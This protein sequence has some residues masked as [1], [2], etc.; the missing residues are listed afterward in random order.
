[1]NP[2]KTEE[3]PCPL[4]GSDLKIRAYLGFH[5]YGVVR[6]KSCDFYYLSPRLTEEAM[7]DLYSKNNYFEGEGSG[8]QN[9]L[10]QEK[11]LRATFRRLLINLSD[12]KL[13]GGSLLEIGCG[14]GYLLDE[15]KNF[16]QYRVG[17]DFSAAALEYAKNRADRVCQGGV[18]AIPNEELFDC[19]ISSQVIEHVYDPKKFLQQTLE[20]LKPRG[21]V[22]IA[23]PDMGSF[24][25]HIMGHKWSSF[26]MPEH[27]LFFDK[28][29][30]SSL[31]KESGI[32]NIKTISYPH[33]FPLTLV[34]SKFN[35]RLPS[36]LNKYNLWIPA[37]TLA[38]SGNKKC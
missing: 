34:A 12:R 31:M 7:L 22:V 36:A 10:Q 26:K 21:K 19:I 14:Y 38:L 25:R 18:D 32:V 17:T 29:T 11:A 24:W 5:P 27:V 35:I 6:C 30:L 1:M 33:A 15:S 9:Y 3:I 13:T 8:Y 16:F 23:T 37:T 4:C 2:P 20:R 28:K